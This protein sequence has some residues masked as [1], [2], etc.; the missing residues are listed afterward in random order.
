MYKER[1]NEI[2][3]TESLCLRK[4]KR[5]KRCVWGGGF[6]D[7]AGIVK[8]DS[9]TFIDEQGETPGAFWAEQDCD[10]EKSDGG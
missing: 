9:W 8:G 4:E 10:A 5:L 6:P 7:G 1:N 2:L 3:K